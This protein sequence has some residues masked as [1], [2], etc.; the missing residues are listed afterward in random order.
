MNQ[1]LSLPDDLVRLIEAKVETGGY[2]SAGD[3][4]RDALDLLE[5]HGQSEA[6]KLAWL[7]QAWRDGIATGDVGEFDRARFRE[8]AHLRL[9]RKA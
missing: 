9:S 6:E 3:V 8:E 5:R 4:V 1:S 7:Q 2:A